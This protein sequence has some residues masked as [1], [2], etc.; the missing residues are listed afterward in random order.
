[1]LE[2]LP[3]G[4]FHLNASRV[5]YIRWLRDSERRTARSKADSDFVKAKTALIALRLE[6]KR[7][8]L[9]PV[10]KAAADMEKVIGAF[11]S[12]LGG[13]APRVARLAGNSLPVR[14]EVD[15]IVYETR[16]EL[17]DL[18]NRFAD[19]ENE[20]PLELP[21]AGATPPSEQPLA[22]GTEEDAAA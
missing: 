21:P 11:L 20:P 22:A 16:K 3:D 10:E 19:E 17:A 14:R 18:F 5:A 4:R 15:A 6:E 9:M 8:L 12:K 2:R 7:K 13:I 1:M